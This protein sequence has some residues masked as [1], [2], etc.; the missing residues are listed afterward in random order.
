MELIHIPITKVKIDKDRWLQQ[1]IKYEDNLTIKDILKIMSRKN[2]LWLESKED[3][4]ITIDYESFED[5]FI[6]L[7]YDK[8]LR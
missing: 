6:Q 2:Y 5:R 8:Y 7:I 3:I 4:N 1:K